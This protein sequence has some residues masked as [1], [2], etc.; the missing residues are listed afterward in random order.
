MPFEYTVSPSAAIAARPSRSVHVMLWLAQVLLAVVF[1]LVGYTHAIAPIEVAV[2]RA[3][4]VASLPVPLVRFIGV[5]ELAGALGL[6]LPAATRIRPGL[7]PLAAAGLATMMAL[8][9]PFHLVRGE[10][11]AIVINLVLGS[12]AALVTWGRARRVPIA[13]GR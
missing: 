11:G 5:A 12:L 13:V 9:I 2:T 10:T 8:A 4:W 7:T 6:V 3:P 1:L